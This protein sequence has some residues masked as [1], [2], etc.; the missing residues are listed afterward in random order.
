MIRIHPLHNSIRPRLGQSR[1]ILTGK[2]DSASTKMNSFAVGAGAGLL[3]S[4]V[5]LGGGFVM[6]PFLSSPLIG[7]SQHAAHGTSLLAVTTTGLAGGASYFW[8]MKETIHN[9]ATDQTFV[10]LHSAMAISFS[11]IITARLGAKLSGRL[12]QKVLKKILGFSMIA[13]SPLV[14]LKSYQMNKKKTSNVRSGD[15]QNMNWEN[16]VISCSIGLFSGFMAGLLGVG[17]G[18]IVVPALT[19]FTGKLLMT[20]ILCHQVYIVITRLH[21]FHM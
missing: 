7:L 9:P 13:V 18:A 21:I 17:G 2:N 8:G 12:S 10:D 15:V 11:G 1:A 5:G 16:V 14:S 19:F 4:L 3:G 20:N 6:I